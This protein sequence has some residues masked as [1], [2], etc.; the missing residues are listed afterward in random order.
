[1]RVIAK[2]TL[3]IFW[4]SSPKYADAQS[5]LEAWHFEAMKAT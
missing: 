2:K 5:A 4:E 1:M 3:K